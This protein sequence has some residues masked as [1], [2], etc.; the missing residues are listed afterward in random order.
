[1]LFGEITAV[2]TAI[3]ITH[4]HAR[5]RTLAR[6]HTHTHAPWAKRV[7]FKRENWRFIK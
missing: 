1:M 2:P 4:A 6:T 5:T 3:Q 7:V